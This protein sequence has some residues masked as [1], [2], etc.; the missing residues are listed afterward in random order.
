MA[1]GV[2]LP[3]CLFGLEMCKATAQKH[4]SVLKLCL[5]FKDESNDKVRVDS[6]SPVA[7]LPCGVRLGVV[8]GED[9]PRRAADVT[10]T[11]RCNQTKRG[12]RES[13]GER[14]KKIMMPRWV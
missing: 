3:S 1:S 13:S 10:P 4:G 8:R 11:C 9:H 2:S 12:Y 7:L 5:P 14:G 6:D